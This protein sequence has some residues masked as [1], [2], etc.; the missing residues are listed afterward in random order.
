MTVASASRRGQPPSIAEA[1]SA[2]CSAARGAALR[3][4]GVGASDKA[5]YGIPHDSSKQISSAWRRS[6]TKPGPTMKRSTPMSRCDPSSSRSC[7]STTAVRT[8][9]GC[10]REIRKRFEFAGDLGYVTCPAT[11]AAVHDRVVVAEFSVAIE[12]L[13]PPMVAS[14]VHT[15]APTLDFD[16]PQSARSDQQVVDLS[17]MVRVAAKDAPLI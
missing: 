17:T 10:A 5:S 16:G 6:R 7:R 11:S 13:E 1:P 2:P 15:H 14:D 3:V 12:L 4:E 9:T 8:V